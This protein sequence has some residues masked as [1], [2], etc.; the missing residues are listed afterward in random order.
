MQV[1]RWVIVGVQ[2]FTSLWLYSH[3]L[4]NPY[5]NEKQQQKNVFVFF[6]LILK[7]ALNPVYSKLQFLHRDSICVSDLL[8]F[9]Y[10]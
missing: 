3:C 10:S 6:V 9:I 8:Y 1:E 2:S 5:N 4:V 7:K